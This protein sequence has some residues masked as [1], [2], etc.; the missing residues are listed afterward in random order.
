MGGMKTYILRHTLQKNKDTISVFQDTELL[1][2]SAHALRK[3]S[4]LEVSPLYTMQL[5]TNSQVL[6]LVLGQSQRTRLPIKTPGIRLKTSNCCVS[7]KPTL[8]NTRQ[9]FFFQEKIANQRPS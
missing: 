7:A 4:K 2:V 8:F 5:L 1:Q 3:W 6:D 9:L